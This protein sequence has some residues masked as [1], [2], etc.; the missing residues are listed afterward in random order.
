MYRRKVVLNFLSASINHRISIV[1]LGTVGV[2]CFGLHVLLNICTNFLLKLD[3]IFKIYYDHVSACVCQHIVDA[4]LKH[5]EVV[6]YYHFFQL[7][8]PMKTAFHLMCYHC[9]RILVIKKL[10]FRWRLIFFLISSIG[11]FWFVLKI[12]TG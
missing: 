4:W 8:F 7:D 11:N 1:L 6:A 5:I 12:S 2:T 9:I 3:Q 10:S